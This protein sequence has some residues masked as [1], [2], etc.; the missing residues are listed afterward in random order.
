[1]VDGW[2][3]LQ[4]KKLKCR[5]EQWLL[6]GEGRWGINESVGLLV[7]MHFLKERVK[8]EREGNLKSTQ[9]ITNICSC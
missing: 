8:N 5:W 3:N 9:Q 4:C 6:L 7:M 2:K 1:M